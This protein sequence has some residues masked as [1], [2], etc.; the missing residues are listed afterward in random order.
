MSLD[1]SL[2]EEVAPKRRQH[3]LRTTSGGRVLISIQEGAD[4]LGYHIQHFR[5]LLREGKLKLDI[6]HAYPGG[7]PSLFA[8]QVE[9]LK[10]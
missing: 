9:A 5:R 7:R 8:D 6:W 1:Q 10:K 2:A 4:R 3:R